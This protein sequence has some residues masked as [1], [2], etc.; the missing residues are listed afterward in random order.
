MNAG[1]SIEGPGPDD[2]PRVR[3]IFESALDYPL[4]ERAAFVERA[5]DGDASLGTAVKEMLRADGE[6]HA[7]LDRGVPLEAGPWQPGD[8]FAS[9]FVVGELLGRGG[10]GEVY[11]ARDTTLGRDIALKLLPAGTIRPGDLNDRLLRFQR[12][13]QVLASLNHPNIAAIHGTAQSGG[14]HA[15]VLELVEG[16]TLAE[17]IATDPPGI[18]ETVSIARQIAAGLEAAHELGVVHR[19]LKPANIKL[20]PDGTV[21]LL[22]FGL[23]KVL[24][25]DPF[26]GTS[27][28]SSPVTITT[29]SLTKG[30]VL[31]GTAA[32]MSPE[33]AK[34]R[35]ANRR[36]DVW[37]FG[38]VLY[39]MLSGRRAFEGSDIPE[40]VASV[41]RSDIDLSRLPS[42][43][44]APLRRLVSRCLERDAARR[45]RDIG[46]AR[47]VLDDLQQGK[48]D[49]SF[50]TAPSARRSLW[51][52][53][54]APAAAAAA[55]GA[56]VAALLWRPAP[57]HPAPV[58]RFVLSMPAEQSVL[59]DPQSRDVGISPDGTHVVYKGGPSAERTRLFLY[60][61]EG[62]EAKPLI[63]PGFP[64][65]PFVSPNGQWVG[66]FEPGGGAGLGAVLK[67]VAAAGGPALTVSR[68][69]G[70][71]RGAAWIDDDTIIAAGAASATGLLRI[72]AAGGEATVLTRPNA[73]AGELDHWWPH[74]LPGG[75]TVLFTIR[76]VTGGNDGGHVA[77]LDL[78]TGTWKTLIRGG[79]Q[80][81]YMPTGHLVYVARGALWAIA[82]D[83][84]RIETTGAA[85]MVVP[86]VVTL[87]TGTAEFDIARDG[88][89]VYIARGG[90]S[91]RPRTIVWVD[92]SGRETP[93]GVPPRAYVVVRL[94]PDETRIATE[95]EDQDQDIWVWDLARHTETRITTDLGQ[96]E[97]PVWTPDGHR[98]IFTSQ[99][100]RALGSLFWQAADGSG[101]AERLIE[102]PY[103]QRPSAVFGSRLLFA[104]PSGLMALTLDNERSA[105]PLVPTPGTVDAAVSP[106]GRWLAYVSIVSGM[107]QIFVSAFTDPSGRRT[108]V[109][110]S[111]GSQP[112]WAG[113]S[114][115]LFYMAPGGALMGVTI[116]P[117][118]TFAA[119]T[120]TRLL[121]N[122]YF[123]GTGVALASRGGMYDVTQDGRRFLMLKPTGDP[124]Q[125]MERP[126]IVVVKNWGE[127]LKR[128]VPTR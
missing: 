57:P 80:A 92:R 89:L 59:L 52:R 13:A 20:K 48:M 72:A 75:R 51:R 88:T 71:S 74:S 41:L 100:G 63:E 102:S 76:S 32:Y 98:L 91:T 4:E 93:T 107:P 34:G 126:S 47:I 81:Q 79:S 115:E 26:S 36:S 82:F 94:S 16:P 25:P 86:E 114:R 15:L 55:S 112:R 8:R 44:P 121:D 106:D 49:D 23:A 17:R 58:T 125:T 69:D 38:A 95:I 103:I 111:G 117:G 30:G 62:L 42:S 29:P 77:A 64:K 61:L 108:H 96:D 113:D 6:P 31:L 87:A 73:E 12:E 99:A 123:S 128:Q 54:A 127:E 21:K 70:P 28:L 22:D 24:Q 109:T 33:Q 1:A 46:E 56:A 83:L 116:T 97:T 68:V 35:E 3:A 19:D 40:T 118:P 2:F 11:R 37:A 50:G 90:A 85:V 39:E 65:A 104:Q 78:A 18:D 45:L 105:V 27:A 7:L 53:L 14:L 43:T 101:A 60:A 67:K 66:F 119:G 122:S 110:P 84:T 5:C 10:M 9:Q 124:S 120:P